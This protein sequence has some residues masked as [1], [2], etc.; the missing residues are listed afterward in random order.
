METTNKFEDLWK[1]D[2]ETKEILNKT[3]KA[4]Q[5]STGYDYAKKLKDFLLFTCEDITYNI[6][7]DDKLTNYKNAYKE[8]ERSNIDCKLKYEYYIK[9]NS[10]FVHDVLSYADTQP[11]EYVIK[12][13]STGEKQYEE[14]DITSER[15]AIEKVK[16]ELQKGIY[17]LATINVYDYKTDEFTTI[18][19]EITMNGTLTPVE[20]NYS[21]RAENL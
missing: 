13:Y 1:I 16:L 14:I 6:V 7:P 2:K 15:G 3:H 18:I 20:T 9:L 17:N 4:I 21:Y 8:I 12:Y 19:K 11:F 10:I 5:A